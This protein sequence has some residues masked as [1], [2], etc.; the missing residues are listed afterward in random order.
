MPWGN[1]SFQ[2]ILS[3]KNQKEK[4][5]IHPEWKKQWHKRGGTKYTY[6]NMLIKRRKKTGIKIE[7]CAGTVPRRT[8][9][10]NNFNLQ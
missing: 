5:E 7:N 3:T 10:I 4:G 6:K 8:F 9:K 1:E 2:L